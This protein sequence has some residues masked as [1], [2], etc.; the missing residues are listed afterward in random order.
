[1]KAFLRKY[2]DWLFPAAFLLIAAG[3]ALAWVG[4]NR[5]IKVIVDGQE[6]IVQSASL[7][8]P[9]ILRSAGIP[10]RESDQIIKNPNTSLWE[11]DTILVNTAKEVLIMTPGDEYV[12]QTTEDIPSNILKSIGIEIFP[13]DQVLINGAEVDPHVPVEKLGSLLIQYEPADSFKLLIDGDEQVVHTNKAT[14]GAALENA[15]IYL[16]PADTISQSLSTPIEDVDEV[17]IRRAKQISV[18][19]HGAVITG[20]TSA[21]TVGDALEDIGQPLQNLDYSIPSADEPLPEDGKIE[22]VR[23]R[24]ELMIMTDEVPYENDWVEDPDAL[25]DSISVVQPGRLGI[26]ATRER[27]RYESGEEVWRSP[28][29][30]WQ[31]S[32][33]QDGVLGYGTK[34]EVRTAV[35]DGQE[36][37][38]W[39]K[40]TVYATSYSPC[41]SGIDGCSTGTATGIMPVQKGVIAVTPRW[42]SVP[43]GYGMWG[44]SVYVQGYGYGIIADSGG[45]I[46]GTPWIDLAY[47][48][49]EY[50][51]WSRW[52]TMYF[53]TPVPPWYPAI[54]LP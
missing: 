44:Q 16:S 24:E 10:T 4:L 38:Y 39:R 14:L 28:Q 35:V 17:T 46:P 40:I 9:S 41:R 13:Y 1:M 6:R 33:A 32:Q 19:V 49:D 31:A 48:D 8:V 42:L 51:P 22:V 2:K 26:Y 34:V 12:T 29:E 37:E 50:V 7:S 53:L 15:S 47:S 11:L 23:T 52:T 5:P 3:I 54:I 21:R 36:I 30:T 43:N 45:G 27:I 18:T 25:L 20:L